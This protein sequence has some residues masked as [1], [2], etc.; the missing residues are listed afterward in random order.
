M[1]EMNQSMPAKTAADSRT[2]ISHFVMAGDI[3]GYGR[4]FGGVLMSWIDE[5]AG[6]CAWRHC[7]G[8]VT[9]ACCDSMVFKKPAFVGDVIVLIGTL[10]YV[11]TSSMEVRVDTYVEK[12]DGNRYPIN[13]AYEVLVA[14]NEDGTSRRVPRLLI[15]G[16]EEQAEWE[17]GLKRS[18]MRK[19]RREEG[20]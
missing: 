14:V 9:T 18:R 2:E 7:Q 13:R 15:R 3:N 16:A 8:W 4:L 19:T 11:G 12:S 1:D 10:T 6:L 20:Y 5:C 17:G